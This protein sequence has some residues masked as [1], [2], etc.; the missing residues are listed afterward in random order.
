MVLV[1]SHGITE[2]V[3][4]HKSAKSHNPQSNLFR[5]EWKN[6]GISH[7]LPEQLETAGFYV[8]QIQAGP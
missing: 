5:W 8:K 2:I 7:T 1:M 3:Q 6:D 4:R